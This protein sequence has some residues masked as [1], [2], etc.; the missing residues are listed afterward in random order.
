MT[1]KLKYKLRIEYGLF[2]AAGISAALP[3]LLLKNCDWLLPVG[4]ILAVLGV[5]WQ[6]FM[7]RCP[8]CGDTIGYPADHPEFCAKCGQKLDWE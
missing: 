5:L 3:I 1:M 7:V 2:A 4:G 6:I 8:H